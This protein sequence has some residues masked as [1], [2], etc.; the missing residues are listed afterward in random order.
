MP[1]RLTAILQV[2]VAALL[3][4]FSAPLA[5][6]LLGQVDAVLLAGLLYLGAGA[7][8]FL[9]Q[10][11]E[12]KRPGDSPAETPLSTSDLPWLA[13]AIIAGGIAAPIVQMLALQHTPASTA[14]LLL[15]FESVGTTIIAVG[16]FREKINRQVI[17]AML[18]ITAGSI[19]LTWTNA[20]WGI[21]LGAFGI[22]AACFLW[23]MDNNLTRKIAD[24][25][26]LSIVAVKGIGAGIF[27][28]TLA[29][30]LG[31]RTPGVLYVVLALLLGFFSYG[32]S[33]QLFIR[34]LRVLGATRTSTLYGIAPFTGAIFS[35]LLF[36]EEP[37]LFFWL[38]M[39]IMLAGAWLMVS[40]NSF[41]LHR[42]AAQQHDHFHVHTDGHHAHQH[43]PVNLL[44]DGGHSHPHAHPVR[45]HIHECTAG[46]H[47]HP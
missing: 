27:S 40:E 17:F 35:F 47:H 46:H 21:S 43:M 24:K 7:G 36:R 18:L 31:N 15:N 38:A 32:L 8:A 12:I 20:D 5:K 16:L 10:R 1:T 28:V 29:L 26:P 2:C 13:G 33:I 41:L 25:N 9:M 14:S 6:L 11:L 22:L 19:L 34:A 44:I 39:P 4:G 37:Q 30:I 45:F 3:F 23:G 42:H